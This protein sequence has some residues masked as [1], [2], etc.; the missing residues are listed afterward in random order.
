MGLFH[1]CLGTFFKTYVMLEW[2]ISPTKFP[3]SC[4]ILQI[5]QDS[6]DKREKSGLVAD[7]D[8]K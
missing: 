5:K 3:L 8:D 4:H 7:N 2:V 6:K 1:D